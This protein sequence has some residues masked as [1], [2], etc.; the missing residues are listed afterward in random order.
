MVEAGIIA[1]DP[2]EQHQA[3]TK[4]RKYQSGY[5]EV[6]TNETITTDVTTITANG[7]AVFLAADGTVVTHTVATGV[8]TITQA[9]LTDAPVYFFVVGEA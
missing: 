1:K 9:A 7:H 6:S 8:I 5:A 3:I 2:V 4:R